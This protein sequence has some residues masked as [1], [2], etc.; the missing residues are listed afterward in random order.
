MR[1]E[2]IIL[3]LDVPLP[4]QAIDLV[5]QTIDLISIY[6]VG[7]ELFLSGGPRVLEQIQGLGGEV[8]LD[9]KL[10]DIPHQVGRA[11]CQ[12]AHWRVKMITLHTLGGFKML[13]EA[14]KS[15]EDEATKVGL[16]KPLMLGVTVLTSLDEVFLERLGWEASL[17]QLTL[18]LA[19][20]AL[21][22]GFDGVVAS[23][24]EVSLLRSTFKEDFLI[25]TPGIRL[26]ATLDD[27][28]R[29]ATPQQ[30]LRA[31]SNYLVVGRPL[32]E[33]ADLQQTLLDLIKLV[34]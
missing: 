5:K 20:T 4:S 28:K 18:S 19:Q 14:K 13:I 31:G 10:H 24:A 12:I 34:K 15:L 22:A 32:L 9:L 23:P 30:A 29:V 16:P 27:Q 21:R 8:F 17:D 33:A 6:K 26:T 2:R 11:C 1:E 25:V 3:A 7:L